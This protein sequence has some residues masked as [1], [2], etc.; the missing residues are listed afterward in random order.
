MDFTILQVHHINVFFAQFKQLRYIFCRDYVA[1][2]E[3]RPL[4]YTWNHLVMSWARTIPT[5][6]SR[7]TFTNIESASAQTN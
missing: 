3:R 4:G 1:S 7:S 2:S 6:F 5:A